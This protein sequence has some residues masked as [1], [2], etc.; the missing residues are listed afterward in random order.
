MLVCV[1]RVEAQAPKHTIAVLTS[2]QSFDPVLQG[3]REGLAR[4]GYEEGKQLTFMI[5]DTKGVVSGLAERAARLV[6]AKPDVLVTV[7]TAPTAAATQATTTVPIVFALAAD[8]VGSGFVTSYASSKSNVTGVSSYA[9]PLT[10]KRLE[11]LKEIAPTIK[12][13]LALVAIKEPIAQS[14]FQ[15]LEETAKKLGVELV[16]RD[17][18]TRE[19]IVQ[20][21]EETSPGSVDAICLVLSVLVSSRTDLLIAKALQEKI[22]LSVT[23]PRMVELGALVSYGSDFKEIGVQASKLVVKVLQGAKPAELPIQTPER[24][25]LTINLH[26]AQAIGL[27]IPRAVSERA[28]R[29]V[30]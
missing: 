1:T 16:R 8:P 19:E 27:T 26:T 5:E 15:A 2:G 11:I 14:S 6:A 12:R 9:G 29:L 17:V 30:E 28:D 10:S 21:L 24:L 22:P 13:V 20:A 3:L 25:L 7:A 18:T 4:A 23:D